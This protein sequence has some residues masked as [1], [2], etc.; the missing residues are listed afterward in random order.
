MIISVI[1]FKTENNEKG[2]ELIKEAL[3]FNPDF[4]VLVLLLILKEGLLEATEN[5]T[6]RVERIFM[7]PIILKRVILGI[8]Y[9][10]QEKQELLLCFVTTD[11]LQRVQEFTA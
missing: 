6:Y 4:I 3:K 8:R 9:M 5:F 2:F 10:I 7:K 11:I 1:Q